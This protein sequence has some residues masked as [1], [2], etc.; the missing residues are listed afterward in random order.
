MSQ[1]LE[2]KFVKTSELEPNPH[3]PRLAFD[4]RKLK[5]LADSGSVKLMG[6]EGDSSRCQESGHETWRIV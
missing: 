3:Q 5:E 4:Q 1:I 2:L 6:H